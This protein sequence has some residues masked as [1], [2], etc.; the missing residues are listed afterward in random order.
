MKTTKTNKAQLLLDS[1]CT[2]GEGP[3]WDAECQT[4]YWVDIE[5]KKLHN[6]NPKRKNHQMW[7]LASMAG[8]AVLKAD[9]NLLLALEEGLST[10]D[11]QS[12]NITSHKV[13]KNTNPKM[14]YNDGKVGPNGHF[15]IGSMHKEFEPGSG[16]LYRISSNWETDTQVPNTTISNGM[17]W[18]KD[19]KTFYFSDTEE[20]R[21]YRFD[22]DMASGNLLNRT[23]AFEVPKEMGGADGMCIDEEDML[24]IAHW[25]GNCIRR[26]NPKDGEVL[27]EIE[28]DAPQVTSCCFG[29]ENLDTLFITTARSGMTVEELDKYP[30]SGGLFT[31]RTK[32][33]GTSINLFKTE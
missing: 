24:W 17:A 2:L 3:I 13:L 30:K 11:I 4:L 9:G 10:F 29:G 18:T 15:Y 19:Q 31:F 12:G 33:K 22:F 27:E 8:A 25:G 32:V 20:Y 1:Q 26:W 7:E 5:G 6:Y 28:V 16:N 14:R 23:I 21:I